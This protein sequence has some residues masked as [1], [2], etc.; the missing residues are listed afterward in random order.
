MLERFSDAANHG[1]EPKEP[2]HVW[3]LQL[4]FHNIGWYLAYE[5]DAVGRDHGLICT[6]RLDRLGL[7]QVDKGFIRP[8]EARRAGVDRSRL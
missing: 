6:E 8:L 1:E 3:P 4:L 5:K 7:R 2:I